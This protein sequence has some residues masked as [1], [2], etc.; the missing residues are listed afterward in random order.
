MESCAQVL[1]NPG[2]ELPVLTR[3]VGDASRAKDSPEQIASKMSAA[4]RREN[5]SPRELSAEAILQEASAELLGTCRA[6]PGPQLIEFLGRLGKSGV[7]QIKTVDEVFTIHLEYGSVLY[8]SSN[9][10]PQGTS[11][12]DI[13]VE[14]GFSERRVLEEHIHS[15][16]AESL[17]IGAHLL[18]CSLLTEDKLTEA[19]SHQVRLLFNRLTKAE[20]ASFFF[21]ETSLSKL[22]NEIRLNI[23]QILLESARMLDDSERRTDPCP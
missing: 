16:G 10:A 7:L 17:R 15:A 21:R 5:T 2:T 13:L 23:S 18:R 20:N 22:P 19:L 1:V 8:A 9:N 14:M 3:A 6:F 11:L 4:L 12:G